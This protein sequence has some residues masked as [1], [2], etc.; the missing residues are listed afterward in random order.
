MVIWLITIK[1]FKTTSN[2]YI[3]LSNEIILVII[4]TALYLLEQF[5]ELLFQHATI[6]G[7]ALIAIVC[8]AIL[9]CLI[10]MFPILIKIMK[11]KF[12][13]KKETEEENEEDNN[14]EER[15]RINTNI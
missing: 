1:P 12:C 5:D 15:K 8:F 14:E 9:Q 10:I 11:N 2:L 3:N 7:W 4:F 6:I 13:K